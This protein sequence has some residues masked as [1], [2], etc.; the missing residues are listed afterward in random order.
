MRPVVA[1]E[2]EKPDFEHLQWA[3][4]KRAD[5]QRTLLALYEFIRH[6]PPP[7]RTEENYV[8]G[9]LIGAAFSLWRAVF[10]ADTFRDDVAIHTSQE[11]FLEKVITDNAI[12]FSDDKQNRHWTVGYYLE[13]AKFRLSNAASYIEHHARAFNL[14]DSAEVL[15]KIMPF[16]R[17]TGTLGVELTRYEWDSAHYALRLLFKI[18]KP[19]T[20]MQAKPPDVPKPEDL[21]ESTE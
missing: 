9:F 19:D 17:L 7:R 18:I 3:I 5:I 8:L 12:G 20:N 21:Q 6:H 4:D 11:Q 13:N 2:P 1:K 16:L 14:N 10:L 15:A